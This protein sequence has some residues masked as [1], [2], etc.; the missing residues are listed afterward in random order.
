MTA[1]PRALPV[2][3]A[4]SGN[5]GIGAAQ[6]AAAIGQRLTV[7]LPRT[8]TTAKP[9]RIR[10]W[11]VEV[12]LSGAETGR[13]EQ[14]AQELARQAGMT[15]VSPRDDAEIVSGQAAIARE[16]PEQAGRIDNVFVAMGGGGRIS[17]IGAGIKA[18]SR[19]S[20]VIGLSAASSPALA[21]AMAAGHV[22]EVARRDMPAD[23]VAG[24]IDAD[25]ITL[26]LARAVVDEVV[27]C[28][29]AEI[30]AA[31]RARLCQ[32]HMPVE[33]AATLARAGFL[34]MAPSPRGQVNVVVLCGVN[35]EAGA[36]ADLRRER[37][38]RRRSGR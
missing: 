36:V 11:G 10:P 35:A 22:V 18:F 32:E 9:E 14:Q 12:V 34:R 8:V 4:W 5:H 7:V 37:S 25:T 21:A 27:T 33:G 6:A 15:D 30:A 20:R 19:H 28:A 23:A 24:G 29:E 26:P 1:R 13:A 17:G 16:M 38:R 31:L 3:T 2:I